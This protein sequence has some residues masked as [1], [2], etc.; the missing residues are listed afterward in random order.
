M[1]RSLVYLVLVAAAAACKPQTAAPVAAQS[2]SGSGS[3]AAAPA[4]VAP[5]GGAR[6]V[7]PEP[8]PVPQVGTA[9]ELG[10]TSKLG[11]FRISMSFT[12]PRV[13]ALFTV[14]TRASYFDGSAL[15]A[16]AT[17]TVDATMPEHRH[18]MM[19]KPETT[20]LVP[21]QWK[22]DGFNL[23]M[24]GKWQFSAH[25]VAGG[26]TDELDAPYQQPPEAVDGR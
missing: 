12:V 3:P 16:D 9:V 22:S 15:P 20:L 25:I 8:G 7:Q 26:V 11:K 4:A 10:G 24:Q 14:V 21:G 19:T 17:L 18:G 6:L 2:A 13:G 5:A 23:H 1:K